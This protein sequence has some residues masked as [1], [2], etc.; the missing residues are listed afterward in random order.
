MK[1]TFPHMGNLYIPLKAV[2]EELGAEVVVPPKSNKRTLELGTKYSPEGICIPFKLTL[3]NYIQSIENGADTLFMWSGC[4]VCRIGY[5]QALHKE[6]LKNL[7]YSIQMVCVEPFKS[8]GEIKLFLHKLKRI[9]SGANYLKLVTI[10]KK[11]ISL[12]HQVDA[13]DEMV[14]KVRARTEDHW[15]VD[16]VYASFQEAVSQSRGFQETTDVIEQY[17]RAFTEI[18]VNTSKDIIKV[19]ITGEIYSVVE[20]FI[21]QDI[22]RKLGQM[23]VEVYC[24]VTASEFIR[25]QI[26]FLPFISSEKDEVHRAAKPYL[27]REIGG[28]ARHTIGNTVRF[29]EKD[30]DGVIHLMPFT[31]MPEIVAQSILPTVAREKR[32]PILKL[33]LDE[34]TGEAGIQTRVEAFI[35]L[36]KRRKN[37]TKAGKDQ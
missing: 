33:V 18:T 3:G 30:F 15:T 23:G 13:L 14:C 19:G 16:K 5:Y 35:D 11:G 37:F 34:M 27:D 1:I 9:S 29:G 10:F 7:D 6:I 4:D 8:I 2:F 25:E 20:P 32:I 12:I 28:H 31:C 22:L 17:R 36:L 26:D 21:N 24:S